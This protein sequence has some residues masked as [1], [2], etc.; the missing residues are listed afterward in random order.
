MGALKV[1]PAT[2]SAGF[3]GGAHPI[4]PRSAAKW[5]HAANPIPRFVRVI[6]VLT[7]DRTDRSHPQGT[8][9]ERW[10]RIDGWLTAWT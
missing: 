5:T 6:A 9:A 4:V 10:L 1:V 7:D 3:A 8:A 2:T